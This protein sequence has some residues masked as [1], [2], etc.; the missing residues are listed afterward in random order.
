MLL[1]VIVAVIVL[2]LATVFLVVKGKNKEVKRVSAILEK[3]IGQAPDYNKSFLAGQKNPPFRSKDDQLNFQSTGVK[4]QR[5]TT[6]MS[7]RNMEITLYYDEQKRCH[8]YL[9][10]FFVPST[11]YNKVY[12]EF[13]REALV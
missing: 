13:W 10:K 5:F 1:I 3:T 11:A 2:L 6:E 9:I 4:Y 12:E 7:N 8:N